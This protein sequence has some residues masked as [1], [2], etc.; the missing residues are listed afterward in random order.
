[1]DVGRVD[2]NSLSLR[3]FGVTSGT[4]WVRYHL[5]SCAPGK[6]SESST[7]VLTDDP[8]RSADTSARDASDTS[9]RAASCDAFSCD[10]GEVAER[11]PDNRSRHA[12]GF[13][14][15]LRS[16]A[17]WLPRAGQITGIAQAAGP[18]CD[19]RHRCVGAPRGAEDRRKSPHGESACD[20][21]GFDVR[22]TPRCAEDD[23]RGAYGSPNDLGDPQ[24]P[25]GKSPAEVA[26]T[27]EAHGN[28]DN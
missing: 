10:A 25:A 22:Q 9:A 6:A 21:S 3:D 23:H 8:L 17:V 26:T 14:R 12:G 7:K 11:A 27:I 19:R 28:P 4:G 2:G 18:R 13:Y 15:C 16:I 1:M 5:S 20:P 24:Y